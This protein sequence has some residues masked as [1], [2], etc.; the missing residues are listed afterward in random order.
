MDI[1]IDQLHIIPKDS[2]QKK[3]NK[4]NVGKLIIKEYPTAGSHVGNFRALIR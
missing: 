3:L 1:D 2:F 4:L